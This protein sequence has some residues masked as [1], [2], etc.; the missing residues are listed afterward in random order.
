MFGI[1]VERCAAQLLDHLRTADYPSHMFSRDLE[2]LVPGVKKWTDW[3]ICNARLWNPPPTLRDT[4]LGYVY[5]SQGLM[6]TFET[7]GPDGPSQIYLSKF[8]NVIELSQ[9]YLLELRWYIHVYVYT[10]KF[11]KGH[12][13]WSIEDKAF[14]LILANM[15]LVTK[16]FEL[17]HDDDRTLAFDF[18]QSQFCCS[19][20]NHSYLNFLFFWY[21]S[22]QM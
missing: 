14:I 7:G 12:I 17:Y 20:G 6:L 22:G 3:M 10:L 15:V 4:A 11:N 2:E 19:R 8:K 5:P 21:I 1:L 13:F 9:I 18:V 16:P